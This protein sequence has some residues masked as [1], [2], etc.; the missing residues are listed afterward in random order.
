MLRYFGKWGFCFGFGK[1]AGQYAPPAPQ[2][3]T[4]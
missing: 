2:R 3:P 1:T 4:E